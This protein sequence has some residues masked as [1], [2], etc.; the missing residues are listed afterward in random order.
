M[1]VRDSTLVYISMV[2]HTVRLGYSDALRPSDTYMR[3]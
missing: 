3:Q 2:I 1:C